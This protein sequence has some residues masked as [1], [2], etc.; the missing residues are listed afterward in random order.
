MRRGAHRPF[1]RVVELDDLLTNWCHHRAAALHSSVFRADCR[2]LQRIIYLL[3]QE[4][5][6]SVA[7]AQISRRRRNR[8]LGPNRFEECDFTRS[9]SVA[10]RKVETNGNVNISHGVQRR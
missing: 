6:G 10:I 4:S 9:D 3:D 2:L 5:C 7:Y 1:D 8:S